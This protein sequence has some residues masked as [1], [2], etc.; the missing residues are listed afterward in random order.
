V[1][2]SS[3]RSGCSSDA[4][5]PAGEFC[6]ASVGYICNAG[7]SCTSSYVA[8]GSAKRD[9]FGYMAPSRLVSMRKR[10][11]NKDGPHWKALE[12]AGLVKDGVIQA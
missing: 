11:I 9:L 6:D 1:D 10:E 5:C 8:P 3:S 2:D 7:K 12:A 4:D